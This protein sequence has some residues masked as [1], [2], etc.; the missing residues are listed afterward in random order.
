MK[1]QHTSNQLAVPG[2][3]HWETWRICTSGK[4]KMGKPN[5]ENYTKFCG[6]EMELL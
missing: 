1:K 3:Q 6:G 4:R 2:L 5:K